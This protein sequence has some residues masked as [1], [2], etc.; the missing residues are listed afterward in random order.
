VELSSHL[1]G[2]DFLRIADWPAGDLRALL[3]LAA[4]LKQ[5]RQARQ[6]PS[7]LPGRSIGLIFEDVSNPFFGAVHPRHRLSPGAISDHDSA[8]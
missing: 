3:D 6:T 5:S 7:L 8:Q 2:H 4:E 1:K